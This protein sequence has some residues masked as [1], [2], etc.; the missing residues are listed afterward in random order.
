MN[1]TTETIMLVVFGAVL[2]NIILFVISDMLKL[3]MI[4]KIPI[5]LVLFLGGAVLF[6]IFLQFIK[7]F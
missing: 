1:E 3:R 2:T 5:F 7:V 6:N 4:F